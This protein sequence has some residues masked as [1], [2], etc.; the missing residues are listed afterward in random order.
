MP[1]QELNQEDFEN[2][3]RPLIKWMSETQ[4]PHTTLI[5]NS[6]SAELVEGIKVIE[7][8]EYLKD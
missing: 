4:H 6:T 7:T 2:A 8:T 1:T 3:V 5:I